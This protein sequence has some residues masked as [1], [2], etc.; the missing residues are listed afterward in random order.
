[1]S[2]S[3][4]QEILQHSFSSLEC[5]P[6]CFSHLDFEYL[7][8]PAHAT[9]FE[10]GSQCENYIL[11]ISGAVRVSLMTRSGNKVLLY[12]VKPGQSCVI[13]T[14]CLLGD[15]NYP[16]IGETETDIEA[17]VLLR[18]KFKLALDQSSKF[19]DLV[20]SGFSQR[21]ADV[22]A[23]IETIH[24]TSIDARLA[25]VMLAWQQDG[26]IQNLTHSALAEEIG[27]VR[28]VVSRHLK[29]LETDGLV[30]LNRGSI[31]LLNL[32]GIRKLCD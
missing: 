16:T 2:Q 14:S 25:R 21:L 28:E 1:M 18:E 22:M 13:T 26:V 10:F 31:T 29:K 27:S 3:S 15:S 8:L 9:V 20:F 17:L 19:R 5:E 7:R 24:F 11:L 30:K 23:R 6:D 32:A 12:R 4:I